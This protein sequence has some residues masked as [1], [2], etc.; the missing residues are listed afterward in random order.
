MWPFDCHM[1]ALQFFEL[2]Y[3][4]YTRFHVLASALLFITVQSAFIATYMLYQKRCELFQSV[5]QLRLIPL[6]LDGRV[7]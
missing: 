7:R 3:L 2:G 1:L 5:R 4:F 6:V